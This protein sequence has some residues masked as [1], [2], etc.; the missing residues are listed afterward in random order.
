[1]NVRRVG[2]LAAVDAAQWDALAHAPSPFLEYGFLRALELSGSLGPDQGWVPHY[3]LAH[4]DQGQLLGAVA[5]FEKTHSYGEFI[6]DFEWARASMHAGVPYYPK[7]VIAAPVTPASGRRILVRPGPDQDQVADALVTAVRQLADDLDC[8]SIHWLFTTAAEQDHLER[9]GF[10]PRASYQFHWH[11]R[12]YRSFDD[13][14]AA[15]AS[16]KRKQFCKERRRCRE[17]IDALEFV[18]GP[19]LS[20]AD[21]DMMDRLYRRNVHDHYGEDYLQPGFFEHLQAL[22]PH[23]LQFARVRRR[24]QTIAGAI[25]LETAQG[26]YGRYWGCVAE[27]EYLHFETAYYAGIERCIERGIPLFEAGA[28]GEHKLLRGFEPSPTYSA[29]WF[30]HPGFDQAVRQ[31]LREEAR[32]VA[33]RMRALA[34]YGP[35]K[36]AGD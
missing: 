23:R 4:D 29:H 18:A 31:F 25:Y 14:L 7:L 12:G 15:L 8:M 6:F 24:G 33:A 30:R 11:N 17:H 1:M 20:A 34:E 19:D 28:Q 13:F 36:A 32:I 35:Y 27:I 2:D 22:A 5:A 16:R 10:A 26:L 21:L 9:R 3:L